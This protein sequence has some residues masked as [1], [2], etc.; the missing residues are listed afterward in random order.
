MFFKNKK[1]RQF[2]YTPLYYDAEEERKRTGRRKIK[3]S[4]GYRNRTKGGFLQVAKFGILI[5]IITYIIKM[6]SE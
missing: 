4:K 2:S 1:I 6:L 3:F 5:F